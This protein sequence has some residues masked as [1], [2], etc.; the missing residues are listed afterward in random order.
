MTGTLKIHVMEARLTRDTET[1][2]KMDPYCLL[3]MREQKHRTKTCNGAGKTPNWGGEVAAFDVKYVGDDLKLS[4]FDEDPGQDDLVGTAD[5]KVSSMC[6]G[7]GI[8]EWY[9]IFYKG[10]EAG[11]VHLKSVWM[12]HG[13]PMVGVQVG[14]V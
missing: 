9:K 8:D 7:A 5:I 2:G 6:I 11:A 13:A 4:V 3:I 1:F 12:P 14:G 10:K